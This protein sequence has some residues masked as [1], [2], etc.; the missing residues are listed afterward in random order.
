MVHVITL[1]HSYVRNAVQNVKL[2]LNEEGRGLK[3]TA[4]TPFLTTYRP[5]LDTTDELG[6]E[7]SSRYLQLIGVLRWA[8]ELGSSNIYYE[9]SV[10]LQHL[11]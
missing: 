4:K 11:A 2:L 3:A 8:V 7:L 9:V 1:V 10:L 5:E 6:D